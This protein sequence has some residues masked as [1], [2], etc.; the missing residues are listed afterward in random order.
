MRVA[1]SRPCKN[2]LMLV[3][4]WVLADCWANRLKECHVIEVQLS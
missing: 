3:L 4:H 1:V 2:R